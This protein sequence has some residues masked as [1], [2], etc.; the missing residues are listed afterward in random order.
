MSKLKRDK[1]L[2]EVELAPMNSFYRRVQHKHIVDNGFDTH[3]VGEGADR[4]VS[5]KENKKRRLIKSPFFIFI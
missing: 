2:T 5:H 4:K 1:K 3:S